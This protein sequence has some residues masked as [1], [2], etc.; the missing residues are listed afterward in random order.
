MWWENVSFFTLSATTS[1]PHPSLHSWLSYSKQQTFFHGG[2]VSSL[3]QPFS[4]NYF[5]DFTIKT[6]PSRD[7]CSKRHLNF[8]KACVISNSVDPRC[9]SASQGFSPSLFQRLYRRIF[10]NSFQ[11]SGHLPHHCSLRFVVGFSLLRFIFSL[12]G[13][14]EALHP[15]LMSSL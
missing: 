11:A 9:C 8:F 1:S 6:F 4:R 7:R 13:M 10:Q 14:M 15:I 12:I 5:S 2:W 3:Q